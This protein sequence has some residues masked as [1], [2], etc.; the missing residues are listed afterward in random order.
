VILGILNGT[1]KLLFTFVGLFITRFVAEPLAILCGSRGGK[2]SFGQ[3]SD[4]IRIEW[5]GCKI[6]LCFS[7]EKQFAKCLS[8]NS[9]GFL[10]PWSSPNP[11]HHAY[12]LSATTYS[13][14]FQL[15]CIPGCGLP[16]RN[17]RTRHAVA[18][19]IGLPHGI[20]SSSS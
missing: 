18:W 8:F 15:P 4:V 14:Y 17:L 9:Q 12:W 6:K 2:L 1:S 19:G 7:N 16:L 3:S 5:V 20:L 10:T 13:M 11:K